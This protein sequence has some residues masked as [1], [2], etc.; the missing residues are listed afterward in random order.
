[1]QNSTDV[2]GFCFI[3]P[4]NTKR[5]IAL[6]WLKSSRKLVVGGGVRLH[7]LCVGVLKVQHRHTAETGLPR[8][9][10]MLVF[11]LLDLNNSFFFRLTGGNITA[12]GLTNLVQA[13]SQCLQLEEIK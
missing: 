8:T 10:Q 9:A 12:E 5:K 2:R 6:P 4:P 3:L 1:M 7:L 11:P 13:S